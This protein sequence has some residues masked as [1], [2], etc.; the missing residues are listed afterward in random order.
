MA[1]SWH[2]ISYG[3]ER[4]VSRDGKTLA[5]V[6]NRVVE[7]AYPFRAGEVFGQRRT[8]AEA[9]AAALAALGL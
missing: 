9:K 7:G 8:F 1:L 2:R 3:D 4:L 5:I 6:W